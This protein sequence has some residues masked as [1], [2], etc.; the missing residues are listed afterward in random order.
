MT[1]LTPMTRSGRYT[2]STWHYFEWGAIL[3]QRFPIRKLR[4]IWKPAFSWPCMFDWNNNHLNNTVIE[5]YFY[6]MD[7][8]SNYRE[9][10]T[11]TDNNTG[12]IHNTINTNTESRFNN[13]HR[14]MCQLYL[15]SFP[16]GNF[17]TDATS[18]LNTFDLQYP[19]TEFNPPKSI[20]YIG[21]G[22]YEYIY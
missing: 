16:Y 10:F 1:S 7:T 8:S 12:V 15:I 21:F 11:I 6:N 5:D 9:L 2:F 18:Y 4:E 19:K 3:R 14:M 22:D 20:N 13:F 17:I